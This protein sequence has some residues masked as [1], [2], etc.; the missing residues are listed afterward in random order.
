M[1]KTTPIGPGDAMGASMPGSTGL[2]PSVPGSS[3]LGH[4][5]ENQVATGSRKAP[6]ME[7]GGKSWTNVTSAGAVTP[8]ENKKP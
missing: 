2:G 8:T 6:I 7:P 5:I 1:A 3:G 4:S